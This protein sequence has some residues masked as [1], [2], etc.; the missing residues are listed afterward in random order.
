M[1]GTFEKA[2]QP[3]REECSTSLRPSQQSA[4]VKAGSVA[5]KGLETALRLLERSADAFPPLK[6]AIGGLVACLDLTQAVVENGKEYENLAN[7]LKTM[8]ETLAPY[9]SKLVESDAGDQ[10]AHIVRSIKDEVKSIGYKQD[11]SVGIWIVEANG[12]SGDILQHYRHIESLF[13]QLQAST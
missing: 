11:R 1:P 13:R 2:D 10:I 9:V 12:D 5:W 6:S 3:R 4:F 7:E 8:A